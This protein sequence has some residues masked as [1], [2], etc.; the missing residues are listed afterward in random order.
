MA[1]VTDVR[2]TSSIYIIAAV[3]L[4]LLFLWRLLRF[5]ILPLLRPREPKELPYWIPGHLL[6]F[7]HDSDQV[8]TNG[9]KYLRNTRE[10]FAITLAGE[11]LYVLTSPKDVGESFRRTDTLSHDG[12]VEYLMKSFGVSNEGIEIMYRKFS[13]DGHIMLYPNPHQKCLARLTVDIQKHQLLGPE[14]ESLS[15]RF[16]QFLSASLRWEYLD[17]QHISED[18]IPKHK[19]MSLYSWCLDILLKA[20]TNAYFGERLL[21]MNPGL[22][23]SFYEFD[24]NSWMILYPVPKVFSKRMSLPLSKNIRSLTAYFQLPKAER[25]GATWF[26]Q[27]LEAEQRQLGMT[28]DDIARL[29]ML[30]HWGVN[31]NT[32]KLCFWVLAYLLDD[33]KLL[34]II[35]AETAQTV[36]NNNANLDRL[37]NHCP[38]LEALFLEVMRLTASTTTMRKIISPTE[39]GGKILRAGYRVLTPYRQLH[40]NEDVFGDDVDR[41]DPE[42]FLGKKDLAHHPSFKPFGGG[43]NYCPGRF[44]ARQEVFVFIALVLHRFDI[45]R[46]EQSDLN[47]QGTSDSRLP[48]LSKSRPCLGIMSPADGEDVIINIRQRAL[49]KNS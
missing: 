41:F 39:I 22:P 14:M 1:S 28:D 31:A 32:F 20:G 8:F 33:T 15:D 11:K 29:M 43:A 17:Q 10:P 27:T 34:T 7:L 5:S 26:N 3:T 19:T 21:E 9:R 36:C 38:R 2:S 42:R 46:V 25:L 23:Q 12:F 18:Q 30:V 13:V 49:T 24:K 4:F 47:Q 16:L 45:E 6:S 48:K 37:M 35:R 40:Y 44:I